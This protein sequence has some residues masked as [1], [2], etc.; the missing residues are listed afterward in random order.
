MVRRW[1]SPLQATL[2]SQPEGESKLQELKERGQSLCEN[3]DLDENRRQDVQ[4]AVRHTEERWREVLRAAEEAL[5][6]AETEAATERKSNDFKTQ[7]DIIQSWIKEQRQ[8]LSEAL[9]SQTQYEQR[10]HIAQVWIKC[11]CYSSDYFEL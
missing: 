5:N 3:Q 6:K 11:V 9:G 2:S 10:L 8:K 4:D 7:G 1:W